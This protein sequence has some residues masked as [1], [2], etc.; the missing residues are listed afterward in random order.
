MRDGHQGQ[1]IS[2]LVLAISQEP[3]AR[4]FL[5]INKLVLNF[6]FPRLTRF[7]FITPL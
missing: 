2:P 4:A 7:H 1:I 5:S 3:S 6:I